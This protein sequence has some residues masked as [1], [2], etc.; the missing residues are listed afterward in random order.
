MLDI[1][2]FIFIFGVWWGVRL[3]CIEISGGRDKWLGMVSLLTTGHRA[4]GAPKC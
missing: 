4:R 2:I 3:K 1:F